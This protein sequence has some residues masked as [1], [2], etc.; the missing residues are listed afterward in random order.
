MM[1]VGC[2][3]CGDCW[4]RFLGFFGGIGMSLVDFLD[5]GVGVQRTGAFEICSNVVDNP[6]YTISSTDE[7]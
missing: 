2:F 7:R 3:G 4:I 6:R 5:L 1:D